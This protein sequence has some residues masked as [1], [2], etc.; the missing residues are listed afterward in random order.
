MARCSAGREGGIRQPGAVGPPSST[1]P[2][3]RAEGVW[4]GP[5]VGLGTFIGVAGTGLVTP[6]LGLDPG[7][8]GD[9]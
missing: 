1:F 6:G 4:L 7:H 8:P 2:A 9:P 3:R 5:A